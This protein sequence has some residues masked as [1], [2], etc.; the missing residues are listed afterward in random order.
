M[1]E[2]PA[3]SFDSPGLSFAQN[4]FAEIVDT[5]ITNRVRVVLR[6]QGR[7]LEGN[8]MN[9][10]TYATFT[11]GEIVVANMDTRNLTAGAQYKVVGVIA[12]ENPW[13]NRYVLTDMENHIAGVVRNGHIVLSAVNA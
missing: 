7:F 9:T 1:R 6:Q 2:A 3:E 8:K 5:R 11:K 4:F 10:E 12:R 13:E